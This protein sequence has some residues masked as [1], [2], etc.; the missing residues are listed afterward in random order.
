MGPSGSRLPR[1]V[2]VLDGWHQASVIDSSAPLGQG[3][4]SALVPPS[5]ASL[6]G[7]WLASNDMLPVK[8]PF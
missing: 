1:W 7:C 3:K 8:M 6:V 4:R 5:R 2:P